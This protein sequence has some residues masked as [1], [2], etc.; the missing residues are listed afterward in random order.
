MPKFT[1]KE[2]LREKKDFERLFK[3]RKCFFISNFIIYICPNGLAFSRLGISIKRTVAKAYKR[4]RMKRLIREF[5]RLNKPN[6]NYDIL[7]VVRQDFGNKKL[8]EVSE[9]LRK[10]W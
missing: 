8:A 6:N 4:N 3:Y 9:E 10:L 7:I 5:F 1:F 2:K